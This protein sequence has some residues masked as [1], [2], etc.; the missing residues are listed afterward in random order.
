M[1]IRAPGEERPTPSE[2]RRPGIEGEGGVS[3]A[4]KSR[5]QRDLARGQADLVKAQANLGLAQSNY[6]RD[7]GG[8]Q[9]RLHLPGVL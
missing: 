3:E 5:S 7:P 4:A 8:I 9:T 1:P 2:T 6:Q